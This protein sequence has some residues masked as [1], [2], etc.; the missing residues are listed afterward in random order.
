MKNLGRSV[1]LALAVVFGLSTLLGL[2][3]IPELGD[4]IT[5]WASILVAVAVLIGVINLLIVHIRRLAKRNAYS[6]LLVISMLAIFI[7]GIT[8]FFGLTTDGVTTAFNIVQAPLEAAMASLL[9]FFLLFAGFRL[10]RRQRN[11]WS[12]LFI[13]TA[14]IIL[15]GSTLLPEALSGIFGSASRFLS[16]VFVGGGMRGLLIGIAIGSITVALRVLTGSARP[17]DK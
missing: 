16:Q 14:T 15:L 11:G 13:V 9:A 3:F 17:Y 6:G 2:L 12:I 4:A 8:D 1:P 10:F 5:T 7:L